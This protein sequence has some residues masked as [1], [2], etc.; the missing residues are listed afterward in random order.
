MAAIALIIIIK[1]I[2]RYDVFY[3]KVDD[4]NLL[5]NDDF[6]SHLSHWLSLSGWSYPW[7]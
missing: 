1:L 5:W 2:L 6:L 7:F 3:S 4:S